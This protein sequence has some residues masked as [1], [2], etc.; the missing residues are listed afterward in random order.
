MANFK[1]PETGKEFTIPTYKTK[2]DENGNSL[3]FDN[4]GK[5]VVNPENGVLLE[6]I[7]RNNGFCTNLGSSKAEGYQKMQ[8]NLKQ[9]AKDHYQSDIKYHRKKRGDMLG[10]TKHN[11]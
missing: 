4:Y 2:F 11:K 5:Q 3:Y 1:C 10:D 6:S 7:P 9:R 8:T